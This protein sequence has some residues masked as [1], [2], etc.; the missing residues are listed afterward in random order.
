MVHR[1]E[2]ELT[3]ERT[4]LGMEKTSQNLYFTTMVVSYNIP[5]PT[6]T[7]RYQKPVPGPFMLLAHG[8]G[9]YLIRSAPTPL[10]GLATGCKPCFV[11][12]RC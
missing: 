4:K 6:A 5:H 12:E 8:G 3:A 10:S 7:G 11:I 9:L 1:T 2:D